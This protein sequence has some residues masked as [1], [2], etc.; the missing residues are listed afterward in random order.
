MHTHPFTYA[1]KTIFITASSFE[2]MDVNIMQSILEFHFI[3]FICTSF[4]MYFMLNAIKLPIYLSLNFRHIN[5]IQIQMLSVLK[6]S[7]ML[8]N[9]KFVSDT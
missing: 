9:F 2:F 7:L 1:Y 4:D 6:D 8:V 5:M 3:V